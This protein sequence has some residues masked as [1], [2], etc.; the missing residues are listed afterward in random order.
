MSQGA[1]LI[2]TTPPLTGVALVNDLNATFQVIMSQNSGVSAPTVGPG[3][4]SALVK[5]M[6]WLDT[7]TAASNQLKI[8]DGSQWLTFLSINTTAHSTSIVM[9]GVT[10]RYIATGNVFIA[11]GNTT[12]SGQNNVAVGFQAMTL[13]SSGSGNFAAGSNANNNLTTGSNN[14]ALGNAAAFYNATGSNNVAI[15]VSACQGAT[16]V[17][18][19]Q[20]VGIG[21]NALVTVQSDYNTGIGYGA[22]SLVT[23]GGYNILIGPGAGLYDNAGT[24]NTNITGLGNITF[25][26]ANNMVYD[27]TLS[28]QLNI[29]NL[30][31]G[32]NLQQANTLATT[33]TITIVSTVA[34]TSST[35]GAFIVSGGIAVAGAAWLG[36]FLARAA[37]VTETNATHTVAATETDLIC[38]RAG[39]ITVTLPTAS[40]N[41]GREWW[42]ST[43]TANTVISNASNVVPQAGGAA[44]TAILAATAGKWA[45]LV[46][47]GTNWIIRASN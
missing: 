10:L 18:V 4:A 39:T 34:A 21:T 46:S 30:I 13:V 45:R 41:T 36:G 43:I 12:V 40:S 35:A 2:P 26:M 44:G 20:N 38:N 9:G 15:G 8:Y 33:G 17:N 24:T 42:V 32:T 7:T 25:G 23:T 3:A 27:H 16:T 5:G 29:G 1:V 11:G 47:D 14:F 37:P 22:G 28:N 31:L 6:L 19:S